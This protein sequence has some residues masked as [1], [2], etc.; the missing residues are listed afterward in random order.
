MAATINTNVASLTAQRNLGL[1]QS[2]LNTSIQRLS[3]GLRINSAKDDAAGMAISERFTSQIRGLNQAARNANDGI[4]LAQTAEGAM[5]AAGDML[6]RIRE[7]AVQSANASNSASDRQALQ[8]EVNQLVSELDRVAQ[9]TEFNGQKLLDGNFGTQRFQVGAN[10]NQTIVAAT[11]NLRTNVYGNNQVS[12]TAAGGVAAQ[13]A[14]TAANAYSSNGVVGGT[15]AINGALGSAD[16]NVASAA[17]AK[18]VAQAIN[19][20]TQSTGVTATARTAV[21]LTFSSAGSYAMTL[22]TGTNKGDAKTISF[23]LTATQGAEGLSAAVQAINEQ[24]SKTGVI[25]ALNA[26]ATAIV[27]TNETGDTIAVGKTAAV[28]AG[29]I[30]A[31][32]MAS[33]GSGGL[34][35]A[36]SAQTLTG[37]G[38]TAV[39]VAVSGYIMLDSDKSFSIDSTTTNVIATG[40]QNSDLKKVSDLDITDFDKATHSLKTVDSALSYIAG[41]RAKLGALQSRFETSIAALQVTSENMSASRGRILDADFAAETANLSRTQI[42][43]QAGTAMVAQANQL[44][45]GVLALL[46]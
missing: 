15:I 39:A 5:K 41:E 28:N 10:A 46:R 3:S 18:D 43:Q 20:Q 19:Q 37:T 34:D 4:S 27:L 21:E 12:G 11:A 24:S 7:L 31:T 22:E 25:A 13:A 16:V 26:D 36:G 14:A 23:S 38:T 35:A 8:Q 29:N 45:Q 6:Q 30:G 40:V 1:S 33:D 44:P 2:S 32:K 17:H 42:L 9:T